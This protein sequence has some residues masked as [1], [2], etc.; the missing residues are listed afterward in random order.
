V[1]SFL[2]AQYNFDIKLKISPHIIVTPGSV[3]T[4]ALIAGCFVISIL[5]I[6]YDVFI[7]P[8]EAFQH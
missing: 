5:L 1:Y 6:K 7:P 4:F 8:M 2:L 3:S